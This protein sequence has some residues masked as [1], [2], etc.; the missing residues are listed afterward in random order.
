MATVELIG[1]DCY[2]QLIRYMESNKIKRI[3]LVAGSSQNNSVVRQ[4]LQDIKSRLDA[5]I[6]TFSEYTPNPTYEE[7]VAGV[8]MFRGNGCDAV[9]AIGGGSAIDIAKCIKLFSAMDP[10]DSYLNRKGVQSNTKLIAIPTTAGTGS[11]ATHF[12]VIYYKGEK[13]SVTDM[14]LI[15][16]AVVLDPQ[17]LAT[18]PAYHKK[19]GALDALCHGVESFWSVNSTEESKAYSREAIRLVI[20]NA[21]GFLKNEE[22]ATYSMLRAANLAGKAINIAKTTAAHAMCYR[23]TTLYGLAH[24]HSAALCLSELWPFMEKH[25]DK[26][27]DFRGKDYLREAFKEL[28]IIFEYKGVHGSIAFR[29]FLSDMELQRPRYDGEKDLKALTESVNEQRMMNNPIMLSE[30]DIREIYGLLFVKAIW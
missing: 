28:D 14:S 9:M 11:E 15:P 18:L 3:L 25:Q 4:L 29:Q 8:E 21:E 23:L 1:D 30:E 6:V 20:D 12:A 22:A 2:G 26:C 19:A 5:Q 17:L 7:A 24:G 13:Q 27:R 16:D 10:G